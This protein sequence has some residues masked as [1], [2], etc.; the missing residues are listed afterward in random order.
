ME[1]GTLPDTNLS[2]QLQSPVP[3]AKCVAE[4]LGR[5]PLTPTEAERRETGAVE[6]EQLAQLRGAVGA[7]GEGNVHANVST[8]SAQSI[9]E[10][11]PP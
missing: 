3:V 11:R 1:D 2:Q 10:D 7:P 9:G 5:H 6:A 8:G 4:V